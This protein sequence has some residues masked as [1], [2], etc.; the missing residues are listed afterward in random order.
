MEANSAG[1]DIKSI[2]KQILT[3]QVRINVANQDITNQQKQIDN[4]QAVNDFL[5]NK[6]TN[7]QLYVWMEG[8]IRTLYYQAYQ[9]AYAW[10]I[11][12]E[13]TFR[14]DRALQADANNTFINFG[15]WD[16]GHDGI[17][18]GE[19]LYQGLKNLEAA[20]NET[21]GWDFEVTKY[22]S[23]RLNSPL[24]LLQLR[25]TGTCQFNVPEVLYDMDFPGHYLRKIRSVSVTIPCVVGPFTT[26]NATLRL[27]NHQYR[28]SPIA[29]SANGYVQSSSNDARFTTTSIPIT[30][31]AVSNG[32]NDSGVFE[33]NFRDERYMPFENAGA[34]SQ[35]QIDLPTTFQQFDY[36]S[37]TD[38]V[39]QI[40]YTSVDGGQALTGPAS[41]S[42]ANYVKM[43]QDVSSSLGL[44]TVFD[45]KNEFSNEWY[46]S[47][48]SAIPTGTTSRTLT[49]ANLTERLPVYTRS[50]PAGKIIATDISL[51]VHVT[52]GVLNASDVTLAQDQNSSFSGG[53]AVGDLQ[54]LALE[55]V[56]VPISTWVFT[57]NN[58]TAVLDQMWLMIRYTLRQ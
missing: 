4:S 13:K 30:A 10:A 1:F 23:L 6:Y 11:K 55:G 33:L 56:S 35:W 24:G 9:L 5:L 3:Q 14:F 20:Y 26:V 25:A 31:I 45:V 58:V 15:Y 8:N 28:N 21:R 38:V 18:A 39:V 44:F 34:I 32:Q 50:T 29:T 2:D 57:I 46:R 41:A 47:M 12:A 54:Q 43:V 40:R 19:M 53:P 16:T 42:V 48:Q 7:Q 36:N 52:S 27:L 37:I 22:Y 17:Y 51:F 49:L